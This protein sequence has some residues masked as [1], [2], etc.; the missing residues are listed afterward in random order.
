MDC[1]ETML[2]PDINIVEG[3]FSRGHDVGV[4]HTDF[5]TT[6]KSM[7]AVD[8][9]TSWLMGHDPR[10]LPY[11]RIANER[12]IGENDIDK[13]PIF[14]L[15]EKG[16]VKVKDYRDLPRHFL[17]IYNNNMKDLGARFF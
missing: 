16:P 5:L 1:I 6:G 7:V 14:L 12:G 9:V 15:D 13:I 11:L 2:S 10:E 3:V 4:M 17:G 8:A